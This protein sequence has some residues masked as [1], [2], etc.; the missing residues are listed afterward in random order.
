MNGTLSALFARNRILLAA[1]TVVSGLAFSP[2]AATE[3]AD[4]EVVDAISRNFLSIP[5]MA[6]EFVQFGPDGGQTSGVFYIERPG[7]IRFN[8]QPPAAIEVI[9]NGR[10]VAIHNKKLKT[11]DFYPLGKTPLKLLLDDEIDLDSDTIR[12]IRAEPDL[13]TIVLGDSQIFGDSIITLMFDPEKHDLRQWTIRDAKGK[14]TSVMIFNVK[15]N[16]ELPEK[17]F[18]FDELSIRRRMQEERAKR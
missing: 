15:K 6:G 12:D 11:W 17:L 10:T 13:T 1:F 7:K 2:A 16:V 5:T 14:E 8:Y 4:R 3:P 9:S 18:A